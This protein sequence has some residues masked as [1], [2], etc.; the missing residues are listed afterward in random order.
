MSFNHLGYFKEY[1]IGNKFISSCECEKDREEI[2]YTGRKTETLESKIVF[3][4][5]KS[6]KAGTEVITIIYPLCGRQIK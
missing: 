2:G 1:Y 3:K 4:N 5:G 6:I